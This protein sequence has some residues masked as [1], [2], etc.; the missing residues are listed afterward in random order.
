MFISI[1]YTRERDGA[2]IRGGGA[3]RGMLCTNQTEGCFGSCREGIPL[4]V[5][6]GGCAS[7]K[8]IMEILR[9]GNC[10]Y[11]IQGVSKRMC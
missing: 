7:N 9:N 3:G 10:T 1:L 6:Q 4:Q 5:S 11:D 8:Q 2:L